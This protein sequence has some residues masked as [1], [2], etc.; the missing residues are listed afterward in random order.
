MM[1]GGGCDNPHGHV[2]LSV[3][4][5]TK[6]NHVCLSKLLLTSYS[7]PGSLQIDKKNPFP[8]NVW[9]HYPALGNIS[10]TLCGISFPFLSY[11]TKSTLSAP[12]H[13]DFNS[14]C[15]LLYHCE[16][17]LYRDG[18]QMRQQPVTT[19]DQLP[20]AIKTYPS[21]LLVVQIFGHIIPEV[22]MS[23]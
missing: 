21:I 23:D 2:L 13:K 15:L 18:F 10:T 14:P 17:E 7:L 19:S 16:S 12:A 1:P 5:T 6:Q 20:Q 4:C 8:A 9:F 3:C 22:Q 11:S